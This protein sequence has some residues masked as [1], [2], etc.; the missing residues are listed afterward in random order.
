[1]IEVVLKNYLETCFNVPIYLEIPPDNTA[2]KFY[3]LELVGG[4]EDN[5]IRESSITIESYGPSMYESA[6]MDEEMI[7]A[8]ENAPLC[9]EIYGVYLNSHY[10]ATDT[11][12]KIYKYKALYDIKH[13]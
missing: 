13:Y 10:N 6:L 9:A 1:M 12:R 2:K 4:G 11:E 3:A 8:M 5:E 7:A